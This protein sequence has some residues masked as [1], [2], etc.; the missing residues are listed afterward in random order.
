[1]KKAPKREFRCFF[2]VVLYSMHKLATVQMVYT[3]RRVGAPY[4]KACNK[5]N[6]QVLSVVTCKSV[7]R[8]GHVAPAESKP[9][10]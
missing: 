10:V 4:D 8:H 5:C 1:M 7:A 3:V 9:Y 6:P 2:V